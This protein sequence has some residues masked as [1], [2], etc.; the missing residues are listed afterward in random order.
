MKNLR[1]LLASICDNESLSRIINAIATNGSKLKYCGVLIKHGCVLTS[2]EGLMNLK[3][4][5]T[6]PNLCYLAIYVPLG[7]LLAECMR[8]ILS[9]KLVIL[10]LLECGIE[11]DPMVV[12]GKLSS[13]RELSL[14]SRS[15]VGE[16]MTCLASSFPQ[17]KKLELNGLP[18][19]REWRVQ[20]GAMS[21]LSELDIH[22]CPCL[23]MV[24]NGLSGMYGLQK[25][26]ISRMPI[27]G[28]RVLEGGDISTKCVML[29][30][31]RNY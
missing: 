16:T 30:T 29:L 12:L 10:P 31:T 13:L 1:R 28:K 19:L 25:L 27:L 14:H 11:D 4:L 7:K 21:L 17:L 15:F 9:S 5:F 20:E 23:K 22:Y 26:V 6:C 24:P 3:R 2:E 18:N 8:D